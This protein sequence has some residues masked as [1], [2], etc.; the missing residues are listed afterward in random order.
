MATR[1]AADEF[2][3]LV[4]LVRVLRSPGG[5]PWDRAQ[6]LKTLRPF[7]L[8]ETYEVLQALDHDDRTALCEELGDFIFEAVLLAQV[9][10]EA[11]DFTVADSL[12]SISDKLVRR[13]PHVFPPDDGSP[14]RAT[15]TTPDEVVERWEAIKATEQS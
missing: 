5:C 1:T 8:E 15:P 7:V 3:R 9:C 11:G 14:A 6:T 2:A 12:Q 13:H 10:S 4:E